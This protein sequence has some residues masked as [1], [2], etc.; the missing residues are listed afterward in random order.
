MMNQVNQLAV[1]NN[2][3]VLSLSFRHGLLAVLAGGTRKRRQLTV[4]R[5]N[6][7]TDIQHVIDLPI[8]GG[9]YHDKAY[10]AMDEHFIVVFI[11]MPQFMKIHFLAVETLVVE[12]SMTVAV[13]DDCILRYH[14]GILITLKDNHIQ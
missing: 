11:E 4:W 5:V 13:T 10:L 8:P 6:S 2:L 7:A 1:P 9:K 14:N 3:R 12:H